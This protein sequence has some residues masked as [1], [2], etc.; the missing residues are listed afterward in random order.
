MTRARKTMTESEKSKILKNTLDVNGSDTGFV[1]TKL[2]N[3]HKKT[4]KRIIGGA[5]KATTDN[6]QTIIIPNSEIDYIGRGFNSL[7]DAVE[8]VNTDVFSRLGKADRDEYLNW[9]NK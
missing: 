6:V 7:E 1:I 3:S 8:F 4:T 9:L 2:D 5:I